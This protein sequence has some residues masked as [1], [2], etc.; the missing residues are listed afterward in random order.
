VPVSTDLA[1]LSQDPR[2]G[3][4]GLAH[5]DAFIAAVTALGRTPSVLQEPHPG[6][7]GPRFTWRRIEALRQ[8]SAARRLTAAAR[9]ARSLWIVATHAHTGAAALRAERPYTAWIATSLDAEWHA[10]RA[11]LPLSRRLA[12]DLNAPLLR[13][14]ERDVLRHAS[15]VFAISPVTA[16]ALPVANVE[17][18]RIP[19]DIERLF[20]EPD[21]AWLERLNAPVVIFVGRGD[22]PRKNIRLLLDA[23]PAIRG[24]IPDARLRLIGRP[25]VVALPQGVDS[26]GEVTSIA[27]ELR[28]A[29]VFVLPSFQ[30]GFGLVV[31]EALAAGVPVIVTPC[32]GPE[33]LVQSSGGG[34]VLSGFDSR[35]LA[36]RVVALLRDEVRI[37]E[38]R[39]RGRDYV[40]RVHDP[41]RL[42][43]ALVEAFRVVDG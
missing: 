32:G 38:M 24:Q 7:G 42:R 29:S 10:R 28:S 6:L 31:A 41:A 2:F 43:A 4:G 13:R 30:E 16:A 8:L 39:W 34:E 1:V 35:E 17:V 14:L 9:A 27:D 26:I 3:G 36:E 40:V 25:P 19:V 23:W 15:R 20:P 5:V 37:Q 22:D 21:S 11:G 18:L 12:F 33:E